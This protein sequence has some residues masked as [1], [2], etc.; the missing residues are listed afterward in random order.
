MKTLD[1]AMDYSLPKCDDD[2]DGLGASVLVSIGS[3][4]GCMFKS[5]REK[6]AKLSSE[7]GPN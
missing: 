7:K 1:I 4:R 5:F 6:L 3:I 2:R